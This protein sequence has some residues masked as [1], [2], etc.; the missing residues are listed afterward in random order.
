ME[1]SSSTRRM[2][3]EGSGIA[4][5]WQSRCQSRAHGQTLPARIE[6][7]VP[8]YLDAVPIDPFT[9]RPLRFVVEERGYLVYSFGLNRRDDGG[10]L[11]TG[12]MAA[13]PLPGMPAPA[14]DLGI[15]ISHR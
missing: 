11:P 14:A 13:R 7:V 9:G 10:R 1:S 5:A 3:D 15:R 12:R 6:D 2:V 8:S 4:W